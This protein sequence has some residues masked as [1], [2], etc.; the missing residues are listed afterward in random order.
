MSE[1]IQHQFLSMQNIRQFR[2]VRH[3]DTFCFSC[4][5][6]L[7]LSSV[8]HLHVL[9]LPLHLSMN[10]TRLY[11][12]PA[13]VSLWNDEILP[14]LHFIHQG[15][16]NDKMDAFSFTCSIMT[17]QPQVYIMMIRL[18]I[19]NRS[20]GFINQQ[21]NLWTDT[22]VVGIKTQVCYRSKWDLPATVLWT[23]TTTLPS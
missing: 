6:S 4:P 20:L 16:L 21:M 17:F 1:L 3:A 19:E 7:L 13:A 2:W 14:Y 12:S 23:L 9:P 11:S 22:K 10:H 5:P 15:R 18:L 8:S